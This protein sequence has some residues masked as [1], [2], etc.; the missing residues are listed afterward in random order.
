M[1]G[2]CPATPPSTDRTGEVLIALGKISRQPLSRRRAA[3]SWFPQCCEGSAEPEVAPR[4]PA[5]WLGWPGSS[6]AL[7]PGRP[8]PPWS[9]RHQRSPLQVR[10]DPWPARN[11]WWHCTYPF[12]GSVQG[13]PSGDRRAASGGRR[14]LASRLS[15][16]RLGLP[17]RSESPV[18]R[19]SMPSRT[20]M[21]VLPQ[22]GGVPRPT[23]RSRASDRVQNPA[24]E[25]PRSPPWPERRTA[26]RACSRTASMLGLV[27]LGPTPRTVLGH[28]WTY[29]KASI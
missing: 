12:S 18:A 20:S 5:S 25:R 4:R 7:S 19:V 11:P 23:R 21:Q 16:L 28:R 24:P 15:L 14:L 2:P 8:G 26:P 22:P 13:H 27:S 3:K 6:P 1:G 10:T 29:R 17:V 9:L